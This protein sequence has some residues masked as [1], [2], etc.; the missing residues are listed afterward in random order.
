MRKVRVLMDFTKISVALLI[1]F[2]R[3]VVSHM[4]GNPLFATPDVPL[5]DIDAKTTILEQKFI[6]ARGGGIEHTAEMRDARTELLNVLFVLALYVDKIAKGNES[7]II[8][9]GFNGTKERNPSDRKDLRL[10]ST[11]FPGEIMARCKA[12]PKSRAYCWQFCISDT[13]PAE[14]A[15]VWAGVSTQ[16]KMCITNLEVGRKVWIRCCG[17][18]RYGMTPWSEPVGIL[19]V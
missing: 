17:V 10:D 5:V 1:E 15:W 2:A 18:T 6:A 19:V 4:T 14:E 12:I 9:S 11:G 8:S 16:T 13:L 7:V 3:H